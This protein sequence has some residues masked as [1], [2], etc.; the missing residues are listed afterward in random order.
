V[1][2]YALPAFITTVSELPKTANGKV[3]RPVLR[4]TVDLDAA[5]V[6]PAA[7]TAPSRTSQQI[8][9]TTMSIADEAQN[10]LSG[11][12]P[13]PYPFYQRLRAAGPILQSTKGQ[14]LVSR[15]REAMQVLK[16]PET[17]SRQL[18]TEMISAHIVEPGYP[19]EIREA[20]IV[21]TEGARHRRQRGLIARAFT[22]AA[23]ARW[24]SRMNEVVNR[25]IDQVEPHGE[26]DL[27]ADY[28]YPLPEHIICAMLGVPVEDHRLFETWSRALIAAPDESP[29]P[30]W[31][32]HAT[33]SLMEFTGYLQEKVDQRRG[34]HEDDLMSVLIDAEEQGD[35]LSN[36]ELI[37]NLFELTIAGHETTANLIGN[38]VYNLCR[39]PDQRRLLTDDFGLGPSAVEEVLRFDSPAPHTNIRATTRACEVAGVH[40][41]AGQMVTVVVAAANR[42]EDQ[43]ERADTFDVTRADNHHLGFGWGTHVCLGAHLSRLEA[44]IALEVLFRRLPKLE[45]TTESFDWRTGGRIHALEALPV[46]W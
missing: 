39:H 3:R 41:P 40:I 15:Y 46:R 8:K 12:W 24:Q 21:A 2:R 35:K 1:P 16:D 9:E 36:T 23:A 28:A 5:W 18:A 27:V 30:E 42:D 22:P 11:M 20:M 37:A 34:R 45:V 19:V 6:S 14:W 4:D 38:A 43:F 25:L 13:D 10:Y 29:T 7:A 44:Q 26:M 33:E 32:R 31:R 17:F